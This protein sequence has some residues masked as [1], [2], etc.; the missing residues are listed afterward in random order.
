[1][2]EPSVEQ[3][4]VL[5]HMRNLKEDGG[6]LYCTMGF[7]KT[8]TSCFFIRQTNSYPC[9]IIAPK[10]IHGHWMDIVM[11]VCQS[12][13]AD[14]GLT[15]QWIQS[16]NDVILKSSGIVIVSPTICIRNVNI[17]VMQWNAIFLD[18]A[19]I[20][21]NPRTKLFKTIKQMKRIQTWL[22]TA[23]PVHN[24]QK[25]IIALSELFGVYTDDI[26]IIQKYIIKNAPQ[27]NALPSCEIKVITLPL[28]KEHYDIYKVAHDE[29]IKPTDQ[30]YIKMERQL[31][32]RQV[33]THPDIYSTHPDIKR[34]SKLKFIC[35]DIIKHSFDISIIFC[36]WNVEIECIKIELEKSRDVFI[37]T[38]KLDSVQRDDVIQQFTQKINS[39]VFPILIAQIKIAGTGLNLQMISRVYLTRPNWNPMI[40]MQAIGRVYRSGQM[41]N[42]TVI[43][44]VSQGTIDEISMDRQIQKIDCITDILED[45]QY[46]RFFDLL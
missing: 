20:A 35:E 29:Y 22:L 38:G 42:V 41:K 12:S 8:F 1:M 19:H 7:G 18:E 16:S 44:T 46:K 24:T 3:T 11:K 33:A 2:L 4:N 31:K 13:L 45:D 5:D 37:L 40:E 15:I 25:D 39:G 14:H 30:R 26:R 21:K 6:L 10:S 43:K 28:S 9:L 17:T 36:E 27:H 34:S 23:T 32:C